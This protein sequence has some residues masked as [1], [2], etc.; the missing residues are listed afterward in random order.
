[1]RLPS[2]GF[3]LGRRLW[4]LQLIVLP[5]MVAVYV[6]IFVTV[7]TVKV[8]IWACRCIGQRKLIVPEVVQRQ[9]WEG[10]GPR[11]Q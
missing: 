1:M 5:F 10:W 4:W 11:N 2:L 7:G 3:A 9:E 6:I 8:V